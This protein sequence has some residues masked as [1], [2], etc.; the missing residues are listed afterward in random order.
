MSLKSDFAAA[1]TPVQVVDLL[2]SVFSLVDDV[3]DTVC[4]R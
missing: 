4:I 1:S 3:I 2:N